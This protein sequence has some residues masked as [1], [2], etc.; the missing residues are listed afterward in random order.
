MIENK[1]LFSRGAFG[2][3]TVAVAAVALLSAPRAEAQPFACSAAADV[4]P[5]FCS[6][7]ACNPAALTDGDAVDLKVTIENDSQYNGG[8]LA[9]PPKADSVNFTMRLYYACT[10]NS[11]TTVNSGDFTFVSA[12]CVA[13]C[14]FTDSGGLGYGTIDCSA[15]ALNFAAGSTTAEDTCTANLTANVPPGAGV[16]TALAGDPANDT[17]NQL[18]QLDE[19]TNCISNVTGGGQGS[20]AAQFVTPDEP[21]DSCDHP[22]KQIIKLGSAQDLGKGRVSFPEDCDPASASF[23]IGYDNLTGGVFSFGSIPAGGIQKSG[24]CWVYKDKSAKSAGGISSLRICPVAS[25]PGRLCVNYKGYGDIDPILISDDM[26]IQVLACSKTYAGP[27]RPAVWN[28]GSRKW[29]LPRS[30]WIP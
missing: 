4:T 14:S 6:S 21:L 5:I 8:V 27:P 17:S 3:L 15:G 28:V 19:P 9:D 12:S 29:V 2:L 18:I 26:Q 16:I 20:T 24:R 23:D 22:N 7:G 25:K 1:Q 30:V 13:G 10:D 11:C